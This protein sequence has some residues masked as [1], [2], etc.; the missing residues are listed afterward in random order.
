MERMQK[1]ECGVK[2]DGGKA[3]EQDKTHAN[4]GN[5]EN[6]DTHGRDTKNERRIQTDVEERVAHDT[7]DQKGDETKVRE[8]D[9]PVTRYQEFAP[10][11]LTGSSRPHFS[12]RSTSS[13]FTNCES[14]GQGP[15]RAKRICGIQAIQRNMRTTNS[16]TPSLSI[17]IRSTPVTCVVQG[18]V[19]R[20][21]KI[22]RGQRQ[23]RSIPF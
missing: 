17:L 7:N 4:R 5:G 14:E 2:Q 8:E 10:P 9:V 23:R 18:R 16:P 11:N 12:N 19:V 15:L 21:L 22:S 3:C 13:E 1:T 6:E 20:N